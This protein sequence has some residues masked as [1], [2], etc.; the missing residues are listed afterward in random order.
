MP[1]DLKPGPHLFA[2]LAGTRR[3]AAGSPGRDLAAVQSGVGRCAGGRR[4]RHKPSS[5]RSRSAAAWA[6]A[7]DIDG[8]RFEASK[9]LIY[10]FEVV[11]RRAGSECDP[12][13]RLLDAKG[14]T[15][16]EADDTP[17][18]GKDSRI[19]WT[20]TGRRNLRAPGRRPARPRRRGPS[21]TCCW[22]RPPRPISRSTC[23]PDM[24]NVGPGGRVP[25]FVQVTRRQGFLG[26]GDPELGQPTRRA[27]RRA[28][29]RSHPR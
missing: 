17:G 29:S 13:L 28:R 18:L 12:V 14:S 26:R 21:A 22:P 20:S 4:S 11:A 23:D 24:I 1:K 2:L 27:S 16:T 3:D 6:S 8:Y 19:E 7:G 5:C 15:V 10:A 25:L 9:G